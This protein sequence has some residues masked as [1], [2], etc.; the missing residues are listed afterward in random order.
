[1]KKR[2]LAI[3][4]SLMMVL[5]LL[6]VGVFAGDAESTT[7]ETEENYVAKIGETGYT[8]LAAAVAAVPKNKTE[9][10]IV[11]LRDYT[12]SG[13]KVV[14]D[15]NIVFN[16]N[17]KTYTVDKPTV[18]SSG[19]ETN[20]FQ[21]LKGSK[22]TFKNGTL[23]SATGADSLPNGG[24]L[25]QNYCDLTLENVTLDTSANSNISYVIS[26]NFGS[27]TAKGNT[28]IKA[29]DGKVAFDLWYGMD[30]N[31]LYDDGVSVTFGD[32]FTGSVTGKIEYGAHSRV[33][34]KDWMDKT[35]LTIAN[36]NFDTTFVDSNP[37]EEIKSTDF[38]ISISGGTF[39][40]LSCVKYMTADAKVIVDLN[41]K[42]VSGG[43]DFY[44]GDLTIKNGTVEGTVWVNASTTDAKYN[45]L[46]V[47]ADATIGKGDY[48]VVLYQAMVGA[49]N[50][51]ST[52]D[53]YGKL[54]G[55][56]WVQGNIKTDLK[57]ATNPCVINVHD[58]A[59]IEDKTD[60]TNVGIALNGAAILNVGKATIAGSTG[61][62]VRAGQMTLNGATV[63]GKATP[64]T[65]KPNGNGTTTDGAGI[66]VAQHTTKLPIEVTINSGAISGYTAFYESN[67]Q[68]NAAE[69][70]AKINIAV[71]GGEFKT[72]NGGT[73][74]VY[75]ADKT[76]FITG[77][78][79]SSDPSAYCA[80]GKTGIVSGNVYTVG[81]IATNVKV[82][83]AAPA[84]SAAT[85]GKTT[86]VAAAMNSA[87]TAIGSDKTT[88]EG[89]TAVGGTE[90]SKVT[91]DDVTKAA[92][93]LKAAGVPSEGQTVTVY[94]QPYLDIKVTDAKID[95]GKTTELT[96]EINPMM[97][98]VASTATDANGIKTDGDDKNAKV[99]STE[100]VTVTAPVTITIPLPTGLVSDTTKPIYI[101]HVKENGAT[102]VYEATVTETSGTHYATFTNPNGFS[103]FTVT[104]TNPAVAKIGSVGYTTL[105]AAVDAAKDGETVE[106]VG[107]TSPYSATMSGSSRTI[108]VKNSTNENSIDVT[109]NGTTKAIE[110]NKTEDFTYTAPVYTSAPITKKDVK[111]DDVDVNAYYAPAVKWAVENKITAGKTDKLF[112]PDDTCTRGEMI[113][114]LW[115]AAGKPAAKNTTNP[116][117]D[118]NVG[119]FYYDAVLWAVENG[120]TSGT[121]ETTFSPDNTVSRAQVVAFLYNYANKPAAANSTF[122]DVAAD[123]YYAP[124]V[125]WAAAQKI[126]NG[127][128]N[129]TFSPENDCT[130]AQI[131]TFLY[132][133]LAK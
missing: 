101:K 68:N 104:A 19:T 2:L 116:F 88:V 5:S 97:K 131:V 4:L 32:D 98:K 100:K 40:N 114:F 122:S 8:T 127:T 46:T 48:A 28:V 123:A 26:N 80:T 60:A 107:G 50:F 133:D 14:A 95:S 83:P 75:S 76:G 130:R 13:I 110:K 17:G 102:F 6:P 106:I 105:Q 33:T 72:I 29:A 3:L 11:L 15:Q 54:N 92:E 120:I 121:T 43:A 91:T 69:D 31:G 93:D 118:V 41:G 78:T 111:F 89:L 84:A 129:N 81:D 86:E 56:L 85:A 39:S 36:G 126:T 44:A 18:G 24:I 59:E 65:V 117:T 62:E 1:M 34:S 23:N 112:A 96:M 87:A 90:A 124:A 66:A 103:T 7:G 125:G 115:N 27:L 12:G 73:V 119:A 67:P 82:A 58:G 16:L 55:M 53:V 99:L 71:K 49:N 37:R 35:K 42:T 20:G 52:I 22:V 77:G 38:N 108:T 61:I 21:L 113:T 63:I 109:I 70:L 132:N 10:E 45:H 25:I 47:A 128:G 30:G 57:S 51:G 79:F 74:A 94:V 64:M 9:T